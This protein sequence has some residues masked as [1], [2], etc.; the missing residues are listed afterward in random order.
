MKKIERKI[1]KLDATG[2]AVGR[3]ST[4][5]VLILRGKDKP[6]FQPHLDEGDFVEVSNC[7][8]M[9]FTGKKLDQKEYIT[10]S[11]YPGGLKRKKVA[12]VFESNPGDVLR[13][14]VMGMLPKNKLRAEMIKR[15]KIVNNKSVKGKE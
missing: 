6:T 8:Q 14:A 11:N 12:E 1:Q 4:Q 9:K 10:H 2:Q 3:L 7:D 5:I 15:L 13:R